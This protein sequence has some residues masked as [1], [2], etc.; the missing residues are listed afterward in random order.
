MHGARAIVVRAKNAPT[1]PWLA[2]LLERRPYSVAVAA[3][4]NKLARTIR[5]VLARGQAQ[6]WQAAH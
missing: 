2:A 6:A 3:V 5:A 1:W 4:A